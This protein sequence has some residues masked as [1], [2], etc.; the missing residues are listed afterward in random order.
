M[1]FLL[2]AWGALEV[3]GKVAGSPV[4]K[5][6]GKFVVGTLPLGTAYNILG[7]GY[8][9]F[10][11]SNSEDNSLDEFAVFSP[12]IYCVLFLGLVFALGGSFCV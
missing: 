1:L 10:Q 3:N 8:F 7:K 6:S 2:A 4:L 12:L 5:S 9:Q 11:L